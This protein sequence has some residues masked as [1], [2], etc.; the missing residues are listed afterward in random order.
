MDA[1]LH[2]VLFLCVERNADEEE[3]AG[4]ETEN[5]SE[6]TPGVEDGEQEAEEEPE[7]PA[8]PEALNWLEEQGITITPQGDC[9]VNLYSY[10]RYTGTF[11][12][13]N[14]KTKDAIWMGDEYYDMRT[15][16]EQIN[17]HP[18]YYIT[19]AVICPADYDDAVFWIGYWS[20]EITEQDNKINYEARTY[21]MDEPLFCVDGYRCFT[22]TDRSFSCNKGRNLFFRNF[23]D[24]DRIRDSLRT[25]R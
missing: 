8:E 9:T 19:Y 16:R 20:P 6:K 1:Y 18:M 22:L 11:F 5:V 17:D 7:E 25:S 15:E 14:K 23:H 21:T 4:T 3:A 13:V 24:S 2:P 10:D 12:R